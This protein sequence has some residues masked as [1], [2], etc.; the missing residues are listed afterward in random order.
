MQESFL[1]QVT[2]DLIAK[3]GG[4]DHLKNYTIV[5]PMQ[6]AG[7]FMKEQLLQ[8]LRDNNVQKTI[9]LPSFTT[10]DQLTDQLCYLQADEELREIAKLYT[11]FKKEYDKLEKEPDEKP[12][13]FDIF[14]TWGRQLL[15]DF[16]NVDMALLDAD[17][18]FKNSVEAHELEG[19]KLEK[20]IEEQLHNIFGNAD[21]ERQKE[22]DSV[23]AQFER[24]WK[25]IP[26]VYHQFT[27]QQEE[28]GL[29]NRGARMR[30]VIKHYEDSL[31]QDK[32]AEK[33]FVFVGFNYLLGGEKKLMSLLHADHKALFYWDDRT[34]FHTNEKAYAFIAEHTKEMPNELTPAESEKRTVDAIVSATTSGQV[35]FVNHWLRQHHKDGQR[36]AIVIADESMLEPVL[37]ALPKEFV[38]KKDGKSRINITKGYPLRN[39][40]IF[41]D[42][43]KF[44]QDPQ[45][46]VTEHFETVLTALLDHLNEKIKP[47]YLPHLADWDQDDKLP[48]LT[49]QQKLLC[50]SY[51]QAQLAINLIIELLKDGTLCEIQQMRTLRNIVRRVLETISLPF[52]GEPITEIQII[53]VLETR[54]LDFDNVLVLNVEEGV[55]PRTIADNSFIPYYLRKYY[56]MQTAEEEASI[57]AYN[58]FRLIRRPEHV[59]LLFADSTSGNNKRGMSRFLMQI[60]TTP[61][62]FS[63]NRFRINENPAAASVEETA[64]TPNTTFLESFVGRVDKNG[65]PIQ[66]SLSPSSI[67]LY[68]KCPRRFYLEQIC[69]LREVSNTESLFQ[70]NDT[71]SLIHALLEA[72]YVVMTDHKKEG[73]ITPE[74]I[75]DFLND[76]T[77]RE[78]ALE[79]AYLKL[80]KDYYDRHKEPNHYIRSQ[81][82]LENK[83]ALIHLEKVL[84]NDAQ[85]A[86]QICALEDDYETIMKVETADGNMANILIKGT[87]DRL[88]KIK[89]DE[90]EKLRILD[91]KTGKYKDEKLIAANLDEVFKMGEPKEYIL[92]TLIYCYVMV[93]QKKPALPL[94][95]ALLFTIKHL[96]N[97]NPYLRF[98]TQENLATL[99]NYQTWSLRADFEERLH[100]LVTQIVN[101]TEFNMCDGECPSYCPFQSL[102]LKK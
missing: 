4:I 2:L 82:V 75:N 73:K 20:E 54:L 64:I 1:R 76:P 81:H 21:P 70:T 38:E 16:S 10:I 7:L 74:L 68:L 14:Y 5:F 57:Y 31:V 86:F 67:R 9:L 45:K 98:G 25:I 87:M 19:L 51:Y 69:H 58:F 47:E 53:G 66:P 8:Y 85:H 28:A 18:L 12:L 65:K 89:D 46:E 48:N 60:L 101:D 59:S 63:V 39:T 42:I 36:T 61:A 27:T 32:L 6:R 62:E 13:T 55:L 41:A 96:D 34:N 33:T 24:L 90:G 72:A 102:C 99:T 23:I 92:Q 43:N 93:E 40:R 30:W 44:L 11:L 95:P 49:W 37:Y 79:E 35:Q 78:A 29:G 50:E 26:D 97:F 83:V 77:K 84:R 71:G 15:T 94:M 100:Q 3:A 56:H 91:Y 22:K 52:H 17:Q 88:D 80:N